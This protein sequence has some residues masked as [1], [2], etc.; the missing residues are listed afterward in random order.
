VCEVPPPPG[1]T[2]RVRIVRQVGTFTATNPIE[3]RSNA[4]SPIN[5]VAPALA[6]NAAFGGDGFNT[7]TL[8]GIFDSAPY[9]RAGQA[10]DL[11]E[12]F[13]IGTDPNFLA[14]A[15]AHWRAGTGG[16]ANILDNDQDAVADLIAFL[17]TIDADTTPFPAA[18]LAPDNPVFADAA[19]LCD[20]EKDPPVGTPMLDCRP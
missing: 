1:A 18:D 9:F 19:A 11:E 17:R 20:C 4:I 7:P 12:V 14:R 16:T 6:V 3:V 5:T 10:Q 15:Q 2:E 8:L 13:G